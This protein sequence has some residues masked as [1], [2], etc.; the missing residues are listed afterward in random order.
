MSI[1]A[2]AAPAP[3]PYRY[4]YR[5]ADP[6]LTPSCDAAMNSAGSLARVLKGRHRLSY[7]DCIMTEHT[8]TVRCDQEGNS[9]GQSRLAM[10]E[11]QVCGIPKLS[12][13]KVAPTP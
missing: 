5:A 11:V 12:I 7:T 2:S 3:L 9:L 8:M 6:P 13:G 4:R 10:S 1:P